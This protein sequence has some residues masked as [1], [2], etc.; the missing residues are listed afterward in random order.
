MGEDRRGFP[1]VDGSR[2]ILS[3]PFTPF[4]AVLPCRISL[5]AF[6]IYYSYK[7]DIINLIYPIKEIKP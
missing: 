2:H 3:N 6:L 1:F 5:T 4:H 7:Y